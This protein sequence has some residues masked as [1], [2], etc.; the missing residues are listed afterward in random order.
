MD[1]LLI[2]SYTYGMQGAPAV[3]GGLG[4]LPR[5][6]SQPSQNDN[7]STYRSPT[8]S[9]AFLVWGGGGSGCLRVPSDFSSG[10]KASALNNFGGYRTTTAASGMSAISGFGVGVA[11]SK[12]GKYFARSVSGAGLYFYSYDATT[13]T[14]SLLYSETTTATSVN[15]ITVSDDGVYWAVSMADPSYGGIYVYKRTGN[16]FSKLTNAQVP[17]LGS[18]CQFA[19]IS[20]DGNTLLFAFDGATFPV[21][22]YKRNGDNFSNMTISPS[23][24]ALIKGIWSADGKYVMLGS[25]SRLSVYSV[26]SSVLTE[27]ATLAQALEYAGG[28]WISEDNSLFVT[29]SNVFSFNGSTIS[30]LGVISL[31]AYGTRLSGNIKAG[32]FCY[33]DSGLYFVDRSQVPPKASLVNPKLVPSADG[34][35]AAMYLPDDEVSI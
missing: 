19:S 7:S 14:A 28:G 8:D 2:M 12:D 33:D 30:N 1:G 17:N 35:V 32:L 4:G 31:N 23:I 27:V 18:F 11:I 24:A 15:D 16:T 10:L 22:A 25:T 6:S 29:G 34:R 5:R 21:I 3:G 9:K 13:R 20:P 26:V